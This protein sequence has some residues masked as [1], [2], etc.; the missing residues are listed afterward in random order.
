MLNAIKYMDE[1]EQT[2]FTQEQAKTSVNSWL[3]LMNENLVT[4]NELK[5]LEIATKSEFTIFRSEMKHEFAA[6]RSE[7]NLGFAKTHHEMKEL[8]NKVDKLESKLTIKLGSII[9]AGIGLLAIL[10]K[11]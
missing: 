9:A 8:S 7:M 3:E 10:Q 6:V 11:L 4:K 5:A 1:L 2:G